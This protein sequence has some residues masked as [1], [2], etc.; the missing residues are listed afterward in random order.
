M[1]S[2]RG[3]IFSCSDETRQECLDKKLF[4]G[5]EKQRWWINEVR[6]GNILFL[7][8]Y[9]RHCLL[10][11]F[12][13]TTKGGSCFES[14]AWGGKYPAQ[15]KV[16]WESGKIIE[17]PYSEI[18]DIIEKGEYIKSYL[19]REE[20][21]KLIEKFKSIC[22]EQSIPGYIFYCTNKTVDEC[23]TKKLLGGTEWH[24]SVWENIQK[25]DKLFLYNLTMKEIHG[26]FEAIK[27]GHNLDPIAWNGDFPYQVQVK[28]EDKIYT[29][30]RDDIREIIPFHKRYPQ[31][32]ISA[33]KVS[34]LIRL[35]ETSEEFSDDEEKF[36]EKFPAKYRCDDGHWVRSR[37]EVMIDN[38]LY[39]QYLTHAYERRVPISEEEIYCDFFIR[40]R[41]GQCYL[42][43]FGLDVSDY[44]E[45]A[46]K[47]KKIYKS[48]GSNLVVITNEDL[49]NLDDMLPQK[50]SRYLPNHIFE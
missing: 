34:Q 41:D 26:P 19:T 6:P 33:E 46:E 10:G 16:E 37:G 11:L 43:Y 9:S 42:E 35:L 4:G 1:E 23:I 47:K 31:K 22:K 18:K 17:L 7:Y 25:G 27:I 24:K 39:H 13:A 48:H 14:D 49:I 50:L 30:Q 2:R 5:T 3:Y 44:K 29:L 40:T 12:K 8:D 45:R 21:K 32:E 28:P 20:T 38:W 36:R 15:V